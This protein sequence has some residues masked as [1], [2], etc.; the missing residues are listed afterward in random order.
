MPGR[1]EGI[2]LE[3]IVD[4]DLTLVLDVGIGAADRLLV[5]RDGD[6][7]LRR[8]AGVLAALIG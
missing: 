7:A 5:E 4:R 6:Q 3:Q 8:A 2:L 1:R